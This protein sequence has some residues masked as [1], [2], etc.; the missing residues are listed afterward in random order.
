MIRRPPRSTLFPYTTLF[1]SMNLLSPNKSVTIN[2]G[3]VK[4]AKA[5]PALSTTASGSVAAGG[6]G[7]DVAHP[8]PGAQPPGGSSFTL[9]SDAGGTGPGFFRSPPLRGH[10]EPASG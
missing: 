1:R 8:T 4:P 2:P 5:A 7:A 3:A 10:R 9:Y 6:E